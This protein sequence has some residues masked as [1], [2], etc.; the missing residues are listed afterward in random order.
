MEP[1]AS[2]LEPF[3]TEPA[4]NFWWRLELHDCSYASSTTIVA[5]VSAAADWHELCTRVAKPALVRVKAC[6]D[7]SLAPDYADMAIV[8]STSWAA[9]N[10][11]LCHGKVAPLPLPVILGTLAAVSASP[12]SD[13][14]IAELGAGGT[15]R[16]N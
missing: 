16:R 2:A 3:P 11:V 13:S 14:L 15:L 1:S 9:M 6:T 8:D 5:M 7:T 12:L 10:A 4:A